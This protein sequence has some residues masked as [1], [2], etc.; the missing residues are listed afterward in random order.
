MQ[1]YLNDK[2]FLKEL[3]YSQEKT[4][5]VRI[6]SLTNDE[7]PIEEII[8]KATGGS[9]NV[10][11]AS[12]VRR[13]C[14]LSLTTV[15]TDP[16]ITDPYWCYNTKFKLQIG[17]ENRIRPEYPDIVWFDMG[18]YIITS[19]SKSKSTNNFNI[20]ISGKDKM[21]RLNGEV[22]GNIMMSTDFGTIEEN[23]VVEEEDSETGEI[24]ETYITTITKLEI[25]K[26][27]Q[28]ALKE[29]A[30]ERPENIIINDLEQYGYELWEYY[31]DEPMY[32]FIRVDNITGEGLEVI[33][34]TFNGDTNVQIAPDK[35]VFLKDF[36]P[37]Y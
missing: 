16:I 35:A 11:G 13:T 6:I 7:L 21:C 18:I 3:D 27:I 37:E 23:N 22:S 1:D 25:Y 14:N 12:A 4:T 31:G 10:D 19:F 17:L 5:F 33:N 34:M 28:N 8:G 29:Y 36:E 15:E 24:K 20:S 30:Q 9:V 32:L 2:E 26:I